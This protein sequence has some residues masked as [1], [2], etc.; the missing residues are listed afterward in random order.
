MKYV[1]FLRSIIY[2]VVG[3]FLFFVITPLKVSALAN[4]LFASF[5][6]FYGGFRFYQAWQESKK[7]EE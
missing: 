3:L 7:S 6:V 2:I 4:N 1:N 5:C